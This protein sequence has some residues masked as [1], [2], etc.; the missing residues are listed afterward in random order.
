MGTKQIDLEKTSHQFGVNPN[1][2]FSSVYHGMFTLKIHWQQIGLIVMLFPKIICGSIF[3]HLFVE[4]NWHPKATPPS[5]RDGHVHVARD[6]WK[7][8]QPLKMEKGQVCGV[9]SEI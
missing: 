5:Q 8:I 1:V 6:G 9:S 7:Q 3:S 2:L 4:T